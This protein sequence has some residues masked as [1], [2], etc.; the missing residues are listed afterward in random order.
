MLPSTLGR[1][2][3]PFRPVLFWLLAAYAGYLGAC[4]VLKPTFG[5]RL[6]GVGLLLWMVSR[7]LVN[8]IAS[9]YLMLWIFPWARFARYALWASFSNVPF[10]F[11]SQIWMET[12]LGLAFASI[13]ITAA[14]RRKRLHLLPADLP[15]LLLLIAGGYGMLIAVVQQSFSASGLGFCY[16]LAPVLC[17]FA[18]RWM[19]P[20]PQQLRGICRTFLIAFF[21]LALLSLA[22]YF[23]HPAFMLRLYS[24]NRPGYFRGTVDELRV[25][26]SERYLR[27]QSL[28]MEENVWGELCACVALAMIAA[29]ASGIGSKRTRSALYIVFGSAFLGLALSMS[30]G[31][32]AGFILGA[33]VL[34]V[35]H[36]QNQRVLRILCVVGLLLGTTYLV[37]RT[38]PRI[39]QVEGRF[40]EPTKWSNGVDDER[41][42]Q[43]QRGLR[44]IAE[45][46]SGLGVGGA[47]YG[48]QSVS[49]RQAFASDSIYLR[50][51]AE[52][53]VPGTLLWLGGTAG[54]FVVLL[55]RLRSL[56]A[57]VLSDFRQA[58]QGEKQQL[59]VLGA[60]LLASHASLCLHGLSGNTFDYYAVPPLFFLFCGL[61]MARSDHLLAVVPAPS[62]ASQGESQARLAAVPRQP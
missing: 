8:P 10:F 30:R 2:L 5:G 47:G 54:I 59:E 38:D 39:R 34:A 17:Y 6:L 62:A 49:L 26:L 11:V 36:P 9:I 51:L 28:L 60:A 50:V 44:S 21:L 33:F 41:T 27:M 42:R 53:G 35:F 24:M 19:D 14:V 1:L 3:L 23:F 52:Q 16:S 46:P 43:W 58:E 4:S 22:D 48:Q 12:L 37:L 56:N 13:L 15:F 20:S 32:I 40:L 45:T 7:I 18:L 29:I 55:R 25:H 61:F 31:A 57:L